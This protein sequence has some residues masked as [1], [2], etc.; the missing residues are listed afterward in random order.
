MAI[1]PIKENTVLKIEL[2]G[3]MVG[4]KQ[5]INTKSYSKIKTDSADQNL[6]ETATSIAGLQDK[7]LLKVKKVDTTN[8]IDQ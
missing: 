8:L 3:G 7:G 1:N 2:D 6:Y 5:K 4:D